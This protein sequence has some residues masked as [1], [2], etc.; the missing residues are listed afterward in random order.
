MLNNLK[1]TDLLDLDLEKRLNNPK[2]CFEITNVLKYLNF[3]I[4]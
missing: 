2:K 1:F 4:E 3:F